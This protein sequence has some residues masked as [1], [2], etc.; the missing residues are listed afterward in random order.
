MKRY[1]SQRWLQLLVLGLLLM[2]SGLW[3]GESPVSVQVVRDSLETTFSRVQDYTAEIV[4]SVKL[5]KF[6]MPRKRVDVYYKYPDKI[7]I[8]AEGFAIV[9][10]GG[11]MLSPIQIFK[12][13]QDLSVLQDSTNGQTVLL[14]GILNPDS[15]GLFTGRLDPEDKTPVQIQIWVDTGKWIVQK[16][17]TFR[18]TTIDVTIQTEYTHYKDLYWL[19]NSTDVTM[20]LGKSFM[21][22]VHADGPRNIEGEDLPKP[23]TD[24]KGS[25]RLEFSH[26]K[27]NK[28]LDDRIFEKK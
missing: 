9:P 16:V 14:S 13:T 8:Q 17:H 1:Y 25:V 11:I 7:R 22:R 24:I 21:G 10:K 26:Y 5:P 19:P 23:D 12:N 2:T 28:G 4:V 20:M 15:S 3:A 6:R 18:D 27:V